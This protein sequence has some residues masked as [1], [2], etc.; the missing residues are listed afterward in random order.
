[1]KGNGDQFQPQAP[2]VQITKSDIVMA[3]GPSGPAYYFNATEATRTT[4]DTS[5]T[6]TGANASVLVTGAKVSDSVIYGGE[7]GLGPGCLWT[8]H[9]AASL[10]GI[11][12]VQIFRKGNVYGQTCAD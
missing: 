4:I 10:P 7:G 2:G 5:K 9:A 11:V 12:F 3:A 8:K 1:V 6:S